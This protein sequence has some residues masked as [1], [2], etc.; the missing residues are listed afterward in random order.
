MWFPC[1]SLGNLVLSSL[2]ITI[3]TISVCCHN[4]EKIFY[5]SAKLGKILCHHQRSNRKHYV[6]RV[7]VRPRVR[8]SRTNIVGKIFWVFVD[9]I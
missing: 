6:S 2:Q 1:T 3:F 8:E 4:H 7:F 5:G 9:G